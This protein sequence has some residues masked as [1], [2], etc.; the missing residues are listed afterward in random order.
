[1]VG[2]TLILSNKRVSVRESV[3]SIPQDAIPLSMCLIMHL[4]FH[5]KKNWQMERNFLFCSLFFPFHHP[6]LLHIETMDPI[7][8]QTFIKFVLFETFSLAKETYD[9]RHLWLL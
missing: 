8:E 4:D 9:G 7:Q 6:L 1:M 3:A 2:H 5:G